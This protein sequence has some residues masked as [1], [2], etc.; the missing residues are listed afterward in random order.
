[1]LAKNTGILGGMNRSKHTIP[2]QSSDQLPCAA[3]S[4]TGSRSSLTE[5]LSDK[6]YN[7]G[8]KCAPFQDL[9]CI[10]SISI[11]KIRWISP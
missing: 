10:T 4:W 1:M 8:T 3:F 6:I 2:Y 7:G 5:Q 9:T 11:Y